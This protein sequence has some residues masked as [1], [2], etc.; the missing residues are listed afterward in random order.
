MTENIVAMVRV[1]QPTSEEIGY[2]SYCYVPL[3]VSED[4]DYHYDGNTGTLL[5][6]S[7]PIKEY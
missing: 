3:S 2:S 1:T 4:T 5:Y 7:V 6:C